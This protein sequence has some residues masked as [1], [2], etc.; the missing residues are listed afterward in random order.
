MAEM[1]NAII[2]SDVGQTTYKQVPKPTIKHPDEMLLKIEAA[3]IC[4]TD[5][6][7]LSTPCSYPLAQMGI[8]EGHEF[9][10]RVEA[11]GDAV[12]AFQVGD[13]VVLDPNVF[14]G[15]CYQCKMGNFN[16]CENVYVLGITVDGGWAEYA[17][18]PS[19]MCVKISP[20][21]PA[22]T[23]IFAEPLTCVVSAVNKIRLLP[24]ESVMVLGA[25]PIGLY[26][27]TLLKANG[28]G[29]IIVTEPNPKRAA[30]AMQMGAD[31][32]IDPTKTDVV[33]AIMKETDGHGIDVVVDAVGTLIQTAVDCVRPKGKVLLFGM[34]GSVRPEVDV[35]KI[36]RN[37]ITLMGSFIG[38][39]TLPATVALMESGLI[40]LSPMVT[41]RLAL[42]DFDIGLE[43]MRDGSAIEVILYPEWDH[44]P[45]AEG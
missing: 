11:V 41:H 15:D 33:E 9:V 44:N 34:D 22:E 4:G 25:G 14:D 20:E 16:M 37:E 28:A 3:S 32:V 36:V 23:A 17:V 8:I 31:L 43:A 29:R 18:A 10:G 40:D 45:P 7:I 2:F 1:M 35:F 27:T 30:L 38:L 13:R 42:K 6:H 21:L 12:T 5:L 39:N 26:F 24:G 19:K